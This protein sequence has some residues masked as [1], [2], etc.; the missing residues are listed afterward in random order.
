MGSTIGNSDVL[1]LP[2]AL[3]QL[4]E[5]GEAALV[6]E[7]I[8]IFQSDAA[9]RLEILAHALDAADY[10]TVRREAHTVK[11]SALQVGANRVAEVCRQ[12]ETEARN[13]QPQDLASMHRALLQSFAEVC[14]AI[15][16]RQPDAADGSPQYGQ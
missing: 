3:R 16:A 4:Q 2:A 14:E 11:G 6:E 5:G 7:L 1:V 15:A 10:L 12:M 13:P 9:E 8:L